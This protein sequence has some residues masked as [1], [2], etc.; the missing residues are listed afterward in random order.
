MFLLVP[1]PSPFPLGISIELLWG[2][3]TGIWIFSW[4]TPYSLRFV[5]GW[6][7]SVLG[8]RP[9]NMFL[10]Y[11]KGSDLRCRLY[12]PTKHFIR[13]L[14]HN[15]DYEPLN[16]C[17]MLLS[18]SENFER[19]NKQLLVNL[20]NNYWVIMVGL[21]CFNWCFSFPWRIKFRKAVLK[22]LEWGAGE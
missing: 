4:T 21:I 19:H 13:S 10:F 16:H 8:L 18:M 3:Y 2:R 7:G 20:Y 14:N 6:Y 9:E 22:S 17:E 11:L 12:T 15:M 1:P 5:V